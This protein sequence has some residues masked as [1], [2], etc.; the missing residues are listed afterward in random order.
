MK[1]EK[2]L[3]VF[4]RFPRIGKSKTRLSKSIGDQ[5]TVY[6]HRAFLQDIFLRIKKRDFDLI[7]A[8][9]AGDT[10]EEFH[11][12]VHQLGS[13]DQF[14]LPR[15]T[16]TDEQIISSYRTTL[17]KYKKAILTASDIPQFSHRHIRKMFADL[18]EFD[19]VFHMNHDGGTCPQGMK[20][21]Y[22]LFTH[23]IEK[24]LAHCQ[25]WKGKLESLRL[26]Y[27]L[28]PEILIDIDTIDDLLIFY[29]WQNLLGSNSDMFCPITMSIIKKVLSL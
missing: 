26:R 20:V 27:K 24:S 15:G 8:A 6:L 4:T 29:H 25:E 16:T 2:C 1:K 19:V 14:L 11:E 9:A 3:I 22:D 5:N 28:E 21:A 23:T 13:F 18:N 7:I 17:S 10:E 12:L